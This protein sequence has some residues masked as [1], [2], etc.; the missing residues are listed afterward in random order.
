MTEIISFFLH[1]DQHLVDLVT[2]YEN[3]TYLILFTVLF[4]E[5]GVVVT[6]FLPGDSLLFATGA[7]AAMDGNP[8]NIYLLLPLLFVAVLAG[9]HSNF[10]IGN[11]IG[12]KVYEKDYKLIKKKHLAKTHEFYE[13]WGGATLIAARFVPIVRTFAPFVAGV[14]TMTYLRFLKF[15]LIGGALWVSSMLLS[16]YFFGQMKFVQDN[17]GMV[18]VAILVISTMPPVIG[19]VRAKLKNRKNKAN[20]Q[21]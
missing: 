6:P 19:V 9:D 11:F 4:L 3:W 21:S 17:F 15:C 1:I 14:G 2:K 13:R 10:F 18:I 20:S 16:G 7:V 12:H 8:L 5:T